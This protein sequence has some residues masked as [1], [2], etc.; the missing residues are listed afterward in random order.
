MKPITINLV[1]G[2]RPNVMKIAPVFNALKGED[3]CVPKVI[4]FAQ[5]FS[6]NMGEDLFRHFGVEEITR[7]PID[8]S[9]FGHRIGSIV[10]AYTDLCGA[11]GGVTL[12]PGDVDV[13][14]GVAL[15]CKR[16]GGQL[17]HLEAGLR[18]F[19]MGMPEE[20]NRIL[21]D[22]ISDI[23][24]APT[25]ASADYLINREGYAQDSVHFVGNVMIDALISVLNP[26][27]RASLYEEY[28]VS[29]KKF[30]IATFHRPSNV[31]ID[32][33]ANLIVD[34]LS[35]LCVERDVIFPVHPRTI[36]ALQRI[37]RLSELAACQ[38][39]RLI[40]PLAYPDFVNLL[41][42]AAMVVTDS[43]GI[44]EEASWLDVP[45]FTVRD[46]TE[47]PITITEGTNILV[48]LAGAAKRIDSQVGARLPRKGRL[49]LWDGHAADRVADVLR[50]AYKAH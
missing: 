29:D 49:A 3:W 35:H 9:S 28:S 42:G 23:L 37:G 45:C 26:S 2:T 19:D 46:N 39:L 40:D 33:N 5:H 24:L 6:E 43:G 1:A 18:S 22:R 10:A 32:E 7:L 27:K 8:N 14:L 47:R 12:V 17:V 25:Q 30:A 15:A 11:A 31:D 16:G 48:P 41:A 21:I 50:Q 20:Q 13:S 36:R 34:L 44:Q 38:R 4:Y